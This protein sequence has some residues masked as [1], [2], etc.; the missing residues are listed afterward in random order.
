MLGSI[1]GA[2]IVGASIVGAEDSVIVGVSVIVGGVAARV[3]PPRIVVRRRGA[4]S[5][6]ASAEEEG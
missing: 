2:S 5:S 4:V 1:V 3:R 6:L